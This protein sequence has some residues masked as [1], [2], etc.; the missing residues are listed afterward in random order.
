MRGTLRLAVCGFAGPSRWRWEL[1]G[2]GGGLLASHDVALDTGCWQFEAIGDLFGYLRLHAAPDRRLSDEARIV[3]LVGRWIG[4]HVLGAVGVALAK[5]AP[6]AV[7]V[8]VPAAARVVA[9]YPL[10]AAVI[11]GQRALAACGVVPVLVVGE[12]RGRAKRPVGDGLR[13][14]GLFSVPDESSALDLRK[15]RQELSRL[16]ERAVGVDGRAVELTVLQYGATRERLRQV[17]GAGAG[18]DIVHLSGHGVPGALLLEKADGSPDLVEVD[19]LVEILQPLADRVKLVTVSACSSA[20]LTAAEQL[21]LLGLGPVRPGDE[22]DVDEDPAA[23]GSAASTV[24]MRLVDR[25][26]CAVLAMRY[27]VTAEFATGLT[28]A[29]YEQVI[30]EGRS[31]S[32][33]LAVA[34][35]R[36][37][38]GPPTP[39]LPALASATAAL[40]GSRAL[41]AALAAPLVPSGVTHE[42]A[43]LAG[44][45]PQPLRLIGRVALMARTG[46]ALAPDSRIPGIVLHGMAGTGKTACALELAYTHRDAFQAMVWFKVA[47][48]AEPAADALARFAVAVEGS[49]RDLTLLH[50]LED[51]DALTRFLPRLTA[52]ARRTRVLIVLDNAESLLAEDGGWKDP[53]WAQ[54]INALTGHDGLS[55]LVITTRRLVA[56]LGPQVRIEAVHPLPTDEAVL[57]A[58]DLP[59]LRALMDGQ[60]DSVET[61]TGRGLVARA[62]EIAR[63][64]PKLLEL[65][66]GQAADPGGLIALLSVGG[67]TLHDRGSLPTGLFASEQANGRPDHRHEADYARVLTGWT[68]HAAAALPGHARLFLEFLCALEE[69]D[70]TAVVIGE[71]WPTVWRRL[72]RTD[73][74]PVL[75]DVAAVLAARALATFDHDPRGEITAC[76]VHPVVS[77]C[78]RTDSDPGLQPSVDEVLAGYWDAVL[79]IE[80]QRGTVDLSREATWR[81]V[82]ASQA[83]VPYLLRRGAWSQ[84]VTSLNKLIGRDYSRAT[85][86]RLLPAVRALAEAAEGTQTHSDARLLLAWILRRLDPPQAE[87]LLSGLLDA[88]AAEHRFQDAVNIASELFIL[89]RERGRLADAL[90]I[91]ERRID[92]VH[93]AGL[94]PWTRMSA[95]AARLLILV[96]QGDYTQA[97]PEIGPLRA[98]M[99]GLSEA[100]GDPETAPPWEARELILDVGALAAR[101]LQRWPDMLDFTRAN[102][103]SKRQRGAPEPEVARARFNMNGPLLDL[104][105][106]REAISLLHECREV[107][108]RHHD[109]RMLGLVL[110]ALAGAEHDLGHGAVALGLERD[111]LRLKYRMGDPEPIALSHHNHGRNLRLHASD[112]GGGA[113]HHMA[114]AVI[115]TLTGHGYLEGSLVA[116]AADL[117]AVP[118]PATVPRDIEALYRIVNQVDGVR[119]DLL[120]ASL[121]PEPTAAQDAL[122]I[123]LGAA[124]A[125]AGQM[126]QRR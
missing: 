84:A 62:L 105:R 38:S 37:V 89:H 108:E 50:L 116:L 81:V 23:A 97:L 28:V 51:A 104:G 2:P 48:A 16:V 52:W 58:R 114:A 85:A 5:L 118:D 42:E 13:M 91:A 79:Q 36:L 60:A 112:P 126:R 87:L 71:T 82:H 102:A 21:R 111:A 24:A 100:G 55:R 110:S 29:T 47:D 40:F 115:R 32:D 88:A 119:L 73:P 99:D 120:L 4:E 72:R 96:L 9:L 67:Q 59:A 92:Y 65:A 1:S 122:E 70:R 56:G 44:F 66:D 39:G 49:V 34:L 7:E 53:R 109:T 95:Q 41:D 123:V 78:I 33:A 103:D 80:T 20:A 57:L 3:H 106:V 12:H 8:V 64:H 61:A 30:R 83:A 98:R 125:N 90:R 93:Q 63:G 68:R 54:I 101:G 19:E 25:L 69:D 117:A 14:L 77:A 113:A 35:P 27:P 10:D 121:A 74:S 15:E 18:W 31:L 76:R 43:E 6:V 107:F 46:S 94:G 124:W 17:V 11:D 45:P 26:D 22:T 75:P 86:A